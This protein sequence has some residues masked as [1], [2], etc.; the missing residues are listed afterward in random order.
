MKKTL[1]HLCFLLYSITLWGNI[2]Q[3]NDVQ[4]WLTEL[5]HKDFSSCFFI[6][7]ANEWRFGND[8]SQLYFFYVQGMLGF[9][10]NE[11]ILLGIGHRQ[12]WHL[13]EMKWKKI[14]EPQTDLIF[15]KKCHK[16]EFELRNRISYLLRQSQEDLWQYRGRVRMNYYWRIKNQVYSPFISN[17]IFLQSKHGLTQDRLGIGINTP[18]FDFLKGDIYYILRFLKQDHLW[19]HQHV[20]GLWLYFYF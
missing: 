18:F 16:Y 6:D 1:C 19:T 5:V 2:N 13:L 14:F 8:V 20:F 12:I 10:I 9:I 3:N 17:E 7:I 15:K 11:N 4:F